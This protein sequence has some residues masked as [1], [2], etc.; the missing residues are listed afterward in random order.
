MI[1]YFV[2]G[3]LCM[4]KIGKC[5]I[6]FKMLATLLWYVHLQGNVKHNFLIKE[7]FLWKM[8]LKR[9]FHE[10][11]IGALTFPTFANYL[12]TGQ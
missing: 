1:F 7:I 10:I 4:H 3:K 9:H 8:G 5:I 6:M 12:F 11:S 2:P